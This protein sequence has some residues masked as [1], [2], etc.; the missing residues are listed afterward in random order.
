MIASML[1]A[2][3][4]SLVGIVLGLTGAGGSIFAVP[5]LVFGLGW[6]LSQATP[7]ALLAVCAAAAFGTMTSWRSGL[8]ARRAALVAGVLGS[9][10][11]PLGIALAARL[12]QQALV[13]AFALV[14]TIV[15]V[16][17]LRQA[18]QA[19]VESGILRGDPTGTTAD[20]APVCRIDAATTHLRWTRSCAAVLGVA[21]AVTGVLSGALGV[22]AGFIIV[23]TLRAVTE[24][25]IQACV[26]TS[27]MI[28][29]IVSAAATVAYVVAH[30]SAA[31]PLA[32]AGPFVAGA[33][34]GM[35]ASRLVAPRLPGPLL[36]RLFAALMIVAAALLLWRALR[37]AG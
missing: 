22:G 3:L 4:G 7:V 25:S 9:L 32:V 14:M 28:I 5:L 10:T 17:M 37:P 33:L 2:L 29:T 15:A 30:G 1:A 36:Q 31:L 8:V 11:A 16:R 26:A 35:L 27:L 24:L 13:V 20:G 21:G 12:P 19:P 6:S 34:A 23:P 18:A